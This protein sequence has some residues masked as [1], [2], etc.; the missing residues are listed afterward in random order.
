MSYGGPIFD[1]DCGE[2]FDNDPLPQIAAKH[3][4]ECPCCGASRTAIKGWKCGNC[5]YKLSKDERE[6]NPERLLNL[7]EGHRFQAVA[8]DFVEG[9]FIHHSRFVPKDQV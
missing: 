7:E 2:P 3:I 8:I 4:R 5:G 1:E 9:E 6:E